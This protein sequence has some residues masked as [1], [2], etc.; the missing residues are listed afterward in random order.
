MRLD[1]WLWLACSVLVLIAG[2]L[3]LSRWASAHLR[4]A[5]VG[6][7]WAPLV[8]T[9]L[10]LACLAAGLAWRIA[11]GG[12]LLWPSGAWPGSAPAEGIAL[13]AG[14]TLAI[15]LWT[16]LSETRGVKLA[17]PR[18]LGSEEAA[19]DRDR[20]VAQ[21]LTLFASCVLVLLAITAAWNSPPP[22]PAPQAR[23]WLFGLRVIA[24]SL[25]LGAWLPAF[26][27]ESRALGGDAARG[28]RRGKG[29]F[30]PGAMEAP[31]ALEAMRVGYPWLT[32]A[33]LLSAAW[34]LATAA[35]LLR[36]LSPEV[37]LIAAWLL[38]AVYLVATLGVRPARLPRW[39]LVLLTA[40][41]AALSVLQAWQ[42]PM[43]LP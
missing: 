13:L 34:S 29:H 2:L 3:R 38:G 26:A 31:L 11:A 39:A 23:S 22:Q 42:M 12:I 14:G 6:G 33:C 21:A 28:L 10:G 17:K 41:G 43:L 7:L 36:G 25:G 15:L 37:W 30:G 16:L 24:A 32:A 4:R 35:A 9:C 8:L 18:V 1:I 20:A 5:R 27:A 40:C 19:E